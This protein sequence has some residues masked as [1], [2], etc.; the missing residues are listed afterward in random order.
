MLHD[1]SQA[2]PYGFSYITAPGAIHQA[3][4]CTLVRVMLLSTV[5]AHRTA[6]S[7]VVAS[8]GRTMPEHQSPSTPRPSATQ[9]THRNLIQAAM[10][11]LAAADCTWGDS[12]VA[13]AELISLLADW[14]SDSD[15]Q[16]D[17]TT[18]PVSV[19]DHSLRSE[20]KSS[21]P[22]ASPAPASTK[23][24]EKWKRQYYGKIVR[25]PLSQQRLT[26]RYTTDV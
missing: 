26:F 5:S 12:D 25:R 7:V 6:T 18:P 1:K 9:N 17:E 19:S 21:P 8:T 22:S 24:Q 10:E 13:F 20:A 11:P 16:S 14:D 2:G 3:P 23:L 4:L 15:A